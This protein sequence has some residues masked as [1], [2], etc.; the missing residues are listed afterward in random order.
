M[1]GMSPSMVAI[2]NTNTSEVIATIDI[3]VLKDVVKQAK[4]LE[5]WY[6]PI[7]VSEDKF[8]KVLQEEFSDIL[9]F[10][11]R[12][13]KIK[14][15]A[16]AI[17]SKIH[18][19]VAE[20]RDMKCEQLQLELLFPYS[21]I[22]HDSVIEELN[23]LGFELYKQYEGNLP[24]VR[25]NVTMGGYK[26]RDV[27]ETEVVGEGK[28]LDG[29]CEEIDELGDE[30]CIVQS[31]VLCDEAHWIYTLVNEVSWDEHVGSSGL[32]DFDSNIATEDVSIPESYVHNWTL[33]K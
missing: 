28:W 1:S 6:D 16:P 11:D 8:P 22:L 20:F 24:T 3:E 18:K 31:T 23:K 32:D 14:A 4:E 15:M 10:T 12:A 25:V 2:T 30:E 26:F 17:I 7:D 9:F 21:V 13:A 19:A 5:R 29:I 27:E 33:Y